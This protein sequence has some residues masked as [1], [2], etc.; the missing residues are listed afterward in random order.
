MWLRYF[1]VGL[2]ALL[3]SCGSGS[4]VG[5]S[6]DPILVSAAVSL[7]DAFTEIA[8][9]YKQRTGRDVTFNFGSSGALLRQIEAGAPADVFASA[10]VPQ[11]DALAAKGLI[12]AGTRSDFARNSLVLIVPAG[13]AANIR[14]INDLGGKEIQRIAAGNP[15]TVP[16]GQYTDQVLQRSDP[17]AGLRAKLI[18]GEDV[19]QVLDYVVRGEVD[20]GFVYATDAAIAGEGVRVAFTVQDDRHDPIIYPISVVRDSKR[21]EAA[22]QFVEI[23]R[24]E[25][26]K[27]ILRKYGFRTD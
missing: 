12:D 1:C 17:A 22:R 21:P 7:K 15:K 2:A 24:S 4:N 11:M 26:G 27:R 8:S 9:V 20:A 16:A 3:V 14:S 6:G 18:F 25:D 23:V 5:T 19:R 13:N 10:G